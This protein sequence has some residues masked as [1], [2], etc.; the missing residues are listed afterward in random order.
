LLARQLIGR[1]S[2]TCYTHVIGRNGRCV[3]IDVWPSHHGLI[4]THGLTLTQGVSFLSVCEAIRDAVHEGDWPV[5]VSL[6]CE[7]F[8][9]CFHAFR[10]STGRAEGHVPVEQQKELVD[11]MKETWGDKLVQK[12]LEG[13]RGSVS[14]KDLRGR[15]ILMVQSLLN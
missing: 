9:Y 15:I 2:S 12:K 10:V 7:C 11:I 1:S 8:A 13:C 3:E 4:V 5:L 6:E 14:P